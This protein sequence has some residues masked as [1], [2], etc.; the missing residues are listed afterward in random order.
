MA[1]VGRPLL[2][3][4]ALRK[5]IAAY[6]ARYGAELN[7]EGFPAYPSGFRETARHRE[8][9]ALYKALG[10]VRARMTA[11][12][13]LPADEDRRCP[14]CLQAS[15][16]PSRTHRRCAGV[17]KLVRELG[18]AGIDRIRA[19]AFPEDVGPAGGGVASKRKPQG[20]PV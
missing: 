16:G 19:E 11:E 10:R 18:P 14:V 15:A 13:G 8:W 3:E 6:C 12:K 20:G 7:T 9:M 17:I 5:R 4:E 2:T 1:R